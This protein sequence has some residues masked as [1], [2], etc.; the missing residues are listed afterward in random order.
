MSDAIFIYRETFLDIF[1]EIRRRLCRESDR[2]VEVLYAERRAHSDH[3][4]ADCRGT[5][6]KKISETAL[7]SL[8]QLLSQPF[9]NVQS[10]L[11]CGEH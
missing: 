6:R 3:A 2:G 1:P 9:G 4:R 8:L 10:A 11:Y 5:L 7:T